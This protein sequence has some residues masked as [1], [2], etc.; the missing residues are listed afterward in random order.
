MRTI[1]IVSVLLAL[2][3]CATNRVSW[4][5]PHKPDSA[6]TGDNYDCEQESGVYAAS[7][8]LAGNPF[9]MGR[10]WNEC[11]RLKKGWQSYE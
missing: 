11:M 5:H 4:I 6:F 10:R 7:I 2:S 8:G 1:L 9:T 3:G